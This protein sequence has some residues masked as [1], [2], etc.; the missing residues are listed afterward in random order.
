MTAK[1]L[2]LKANSSDPPVGELYINYLSSVRPNLSEIYW[3]TSKEINFKF[4]LRHTRMHIS[5]FAW[6]NFLLHWLD[7]NLLL[8]GGIL[9]ASLVKST[10]QVK[11]EWTGET[12]FQLPDGFVLDTSASVS[13]YLARITPGCNLYGNSPIERSEVTNFILKVELNLINLNSK[14]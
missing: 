1:T 2:I 5:F 14:I 3:K 9:T 8:T 7:D 4:S 13:R 10:H 12:C 11:V 6:C